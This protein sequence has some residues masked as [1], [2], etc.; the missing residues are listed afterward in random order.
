MCVYFTEDRKT[1]K[2]ETTSAWVNNDYLTNIS[3]NY[4][5]KYLD[6][7]CVSVCKYVAGD[8]EI[9]VK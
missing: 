6:R 4:P 7:S 3:M 5:F 2:F 9:K 1:C 8:S